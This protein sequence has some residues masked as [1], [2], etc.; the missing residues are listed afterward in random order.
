MFEDGRED[1]PDARC[2]GNRSEMTWFSGFAFAAFLGM[3]W[4]TPSLQAC[5][6]DPF[7]QHDLYRSRRAGSSEGYCFRMLYKMWSR[8]LG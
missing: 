4:I 6:T 3:R 8:G 5:G 1:L 2:Y 7:L